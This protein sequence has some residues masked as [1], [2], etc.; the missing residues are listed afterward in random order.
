MN[1]IN[2]IR[3]SIR[4]TP[5]LPRPFCH[6][7]A[8]CEV[9]LPLARKQALTAH[10]ICQCLDAALPSLQNC[11]KKMSVVYKP[12]SMVFHDRSSNGLTQGQW[13]EFR[14]W[15]VN[16][17]D[18]NYIFIFTNLKWRFISISVHYIPRCRHHRTVALAVP[19]TWLAIEIRYFPS[20]YKL[21][22]TSQHFINVHPPLLDL[23]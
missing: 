12:P 15:S 8:Q 17:N 3:E 18:Q 14:G 16:I 2:A 7:G 1:G 23:I 20:H 19:L 21:F 11:E 9:S 22:Q 6:V 4:E 13:I 5:E 10:G